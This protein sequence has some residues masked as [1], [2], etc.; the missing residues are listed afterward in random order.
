MTTGPSVYDLFDLQETCPSHARPTTF[1]Q[2]K[3]DRFGAWAGVP[4]GFDRQ[5]VAVLQLYSTTLQ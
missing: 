1:P 5:P 4:G 2:L 3:G